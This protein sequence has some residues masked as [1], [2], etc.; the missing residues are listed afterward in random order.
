MPLIPAMGQQRQWDFHEARVASITNV[1][2][3]KEGHP[4]CLAEQQKAVLLLHVKLQA[5]DDLRGTKV[6][7]K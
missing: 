3:E 2:K 4:R 5:H 1:R 7:S 6:T